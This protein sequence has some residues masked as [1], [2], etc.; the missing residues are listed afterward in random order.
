M[1][2]VRFRQ[3]LEARSTLTLATPVPGAVAVVVATLMTI[4]KTCRCGPRAHILELTNRCAA[5][6][7]RARHCPCLPNA[8]S[9]PISIEYFVEAFPIRMRCTKQ[10]PQRRLQC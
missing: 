10:R 2:Q 6:E 9:L 5:F 7:S 1:T 4:R 8:A 3:I